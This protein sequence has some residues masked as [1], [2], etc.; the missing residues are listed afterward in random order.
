MNILHIQN[1]FYLISYLNL[2]FE[3]WKTLA[4][5]LFLDTATDPVLIARSW[6][7]HTSTSHECLC[8]GFVGIVPVMY[9][10]Y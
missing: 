1:S 6:Y 8:V 2:S 4:P 10:R 9:H 5:V 7:T 3:L